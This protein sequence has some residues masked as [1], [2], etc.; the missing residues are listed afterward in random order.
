V[1]SNQVRRLGPS[2]ASEARRLGALIFGRTDLQGESAAE[3]RLTCVSLFLDLCLWTEEQD[4]AADIRLFAEDSSKFADEAARIVFHIREILVAGPIDPPDPTFEKA[5]ARAFRSLEAIVSSAQSGC[6]AL[7]R[8]HEQLPVDAWPTEDQEK[9]RKLAQVIDSVATQLYFASGAFVEKSNKD[10][11]QPVSVEQ[12]KRLLVEASRLLDLLSS[13]PHP[14]TVHHLVEMLLSLL[15][16]SPREVF[17]RIN[18]IVKA[19]KAGGYQRESLAIG[20]IV[21]VVN[22]VLADYRPLLQ[23]DQ[24]MR[25]AMVSILDV[26][27]EAGWAQAIQLTY[28]LDEIFR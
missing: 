7:Q 1:L 9:L 13:D 24:E 19:G 28:R 5:R 22:R 11:M 20:E 2:Q 18:S 8:A 4:S 10:E 6:M 25:E 27:V 14:S 21:N 17:L 16:I 3:V 12:K 26:F 15:D 23:S